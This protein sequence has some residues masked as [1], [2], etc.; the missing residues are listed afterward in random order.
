MTDVNR[1]KKQYPSYYTYERSDVLNLCSELNSKG[2]SKQ[3]WK[4]PVNNNFDVA[5]GQFT[6]EDFFAMNYNFPAVIGVFENPK[7][8][9]IIKIMFV[10]NSS[11]MKKFNDFTF[12]SSQSEGPKYYIESKDEIRAIGLTD[13]MKRLLKKHNRNKGPQY[14]FASVL[15]VISFLYVI[16]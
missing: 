4:V 6:S 12:P 5:K 2:W 7:N 9:D 10:N 14:A 3:S 1:L 16:G 13:Y 8:H 11:S 15:N